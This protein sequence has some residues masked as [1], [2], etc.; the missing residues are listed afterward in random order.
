[1]LFTNS[2]PYGN[3]YNW[4]D[5]ELELFNEHFKEILISPYTYEG[6]KVPKKLPDY[7]NVKIKHPV[8]EEDIQFRS[9]W[10]I[11]KIFSRRLIYYF[12]EFI[13]EKLYSNSY[14][15][16]NWIQAILKTEMMLNSVIWKILE[17][18]PNKEE[19]VLYF[20]WGNNQSLMIPLLKENRL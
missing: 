19:T 15:F 10:Q 14:W 6:N 13:S 16:K 8:I 4:L 1:M 7:E 20:Y 18:I 11:R 3:G 9:I 2:Y 17:S 5:A 12:K